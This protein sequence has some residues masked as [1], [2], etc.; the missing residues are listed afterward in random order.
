[1]GLFNGRLFRLKEGRMK[2]E[3]FPEIIGVFCGFGVGV[4]I[5]I[6]LLRI[7]P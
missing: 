5:L 7:I 6:A 4:A 1:M 3:E 2:D